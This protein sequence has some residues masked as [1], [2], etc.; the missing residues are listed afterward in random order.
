MGGANHARLRRGEQDNATISPGD[1]KA[2]ARRG[3]DERVASRPSL[4]R[5]GRGDRQSVGRMHL[6]G[7]QQMGRLDSERP[8]HTG[9]ILAHG[10]GVVARSDTSIQRSIDALRDAAAASEESVR[11]A[12]RAQGR[13]LQKFRARVAQ[14][15]APASAWNPGGTGNCRL[16]TTIALNSPPISP[17]PLPVSR[18]RAASISAAWEAPARLV[19]A[20]AR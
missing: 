8:R 3:G 5:P 20:C 12:G 6:V 11:D 16:A 18:I 1:A 15:A 4:G 17:T 10:I 9:A 14:G 13:R 19:S 7:N 2:E